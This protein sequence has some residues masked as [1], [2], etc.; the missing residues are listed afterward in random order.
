MSTPTANTSPIWSAAPDVGRVV[1]DQASTNVNTNSAGT[2]GTNTFLAFSTG[3]DGSFIQKIR[4]TFT[5]TTSAINSVATTLNF[6]IS[7]VSSGSP[8]AAQ[9]T[10][11]QGVQAAAQTLTATTPPY[12][13]EV[14]LDIGLPTGYHILVGQT[15]AQSANSNWNAIVFAGDY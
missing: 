10:S 14:P 5:S 12:I 9:A 11:L 2:I 15:I 4:F 3:T 6:Y 1:I 7:T 8:T 13:I